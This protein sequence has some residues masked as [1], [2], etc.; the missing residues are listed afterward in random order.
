MLLPT[1]PMGDIETPIKDSLL[2]VIFFQHRQV[3]LPRLDL[4]TRRISLPQKQ[5]QVV[6]EII[7]EA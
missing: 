1:S 3:A 4:S 2:Q 7:P 6:A 5:L